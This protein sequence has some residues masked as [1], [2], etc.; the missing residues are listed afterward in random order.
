[1]MVVKNNL[2]LPILFIDQSIVYICS[3][4]RWVV[5]LIYTCKLLPDAMMR[6][7]LLTLEIARGNSRRNLACIPV[8]RRSW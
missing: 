6:A 7:C 4:R 1:A 3:K 8:S 2:R 5:S